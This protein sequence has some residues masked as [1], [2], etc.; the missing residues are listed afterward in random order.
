MQHIFSF[1]NLIL[2]S[3]SR[4]KSTENVSRPGS[5]GRN[6]SPSMQQEKAAHEES[7]QQET[8]AAAAP[9]AQQEATPTPTVSIFMQVVEFLLEVKAMPVSNF[10]LSSLY[11]LSC[12][13]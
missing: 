1:Y 11:I 9:A 4:L 12:Y 7:H 5:V 8:S 13:I 2:F 10:F 3:A 6:K